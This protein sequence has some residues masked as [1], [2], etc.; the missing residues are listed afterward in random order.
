VGKGGDRRADRDL[1]NPR[2]LTWETTM[3]TSFD[4][5][6]DALILH[7]HRSGPGAADSFH[8][9]EGFDCGDTRRLVQHLEELGLVIP[10]YVLAETRCSLTGSGVRRAEQLIKERPRRHAMTLRRRMLQWLDELEEHNVVTA[11]WDD[12]L[13]SDHARF[14]GTTF[15]EAQL[16]RE[17]E[18][19]FGR[20]L[21]TAVSINEDV[22]GM[23]CPR[24]AP[25]GRDLLYEGGGSST[26]ATITN[27]FFGPVINGTASGSQ[28][29]WGNTAAN[30]VGQ[31]QRVDRGLDS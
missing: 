12:F 23:V 15:T 28:F 21:I 6:C 10:T 3:T 18:Y 8:A 29:S 19:L 1:L 9:N 16:R 5:H 26:G 24:L 11:A 20:G 7:L 4:E 13:T 27:T 17:A 31:G 30:Q 2:I 22:D 25:A 14:E